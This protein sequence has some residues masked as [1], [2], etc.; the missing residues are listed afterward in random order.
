M[1]ETM[2]WAP[3]RAKGRR[4]RWRRSVPRWDKAFQGGYVYCG[5]RK[6]TSIGMSGERAEVPTCTRV[7]RFEKKLLRGSREGECSRVSQ[8]RR[9]Q[10]GRQGIY[11]VD[12]NREG[13][14]GWEEE[15]EDSRRPWITKAE[16]G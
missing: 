16:M 9:R 1:R 15:C 12:A 13:G 4:V 14:K 2:E 11:F 6:F 7:A 5:Q 10:E 3:G 8:R